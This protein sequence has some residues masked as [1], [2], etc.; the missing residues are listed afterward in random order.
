MQLA[1]GWKRSIVAAAATLSVT[2]AA[3]PTPADADTDLRGRI[4]MLEHE[5]DSRPR[6][7][8]EALEALTPQSEPYS[9]ERLELYTVR[10]LLLA[11]AAEPEAADRIAQALDDWAKNRGSSDAAAAAQLVRA[12]AILQRGNLQQADHLLTEATARL[13]ANVPPAVKVRFLQVHGRV[14]DDSGRIDEAARLLHEALVLADADGA[15]WR[16][17]ELRTLLAYVYYEGQA[18]RARAQPQRRSARDR[19]ACR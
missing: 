11:Q 5:G 12:R 8:A 16:R 10:G 14:K 18:A 15:P 7:A 6:E 17:A 4:R 19:G 3:A 9:D 1:P 2:L 13:P